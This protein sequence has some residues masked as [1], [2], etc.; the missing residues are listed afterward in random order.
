LEEGL[1][2]KITGGMTSGVP[3][4]AIEFMLS[5]ISSLNLTRRNRQSAIGN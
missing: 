3:L 1:A 4:P 2:T 5:E